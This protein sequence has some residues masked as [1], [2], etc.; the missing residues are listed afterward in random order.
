MGFSFFGRLRK[1]GMDKA[2]FDEIVLAMLWFNERAAGLGL[3][4]L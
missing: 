2:K 1:I 3:E 4:G